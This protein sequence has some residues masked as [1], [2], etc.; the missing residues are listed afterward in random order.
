MNSPSL[1][2]SIRKV[3][4]LVAATL[5]LPAL[6]YAQNNQGDEGRGFRPGIPNGT[7]AFQAS[8]YVSGTPVHSAAQLTFFANGTIT[9]LRSSSF[10][11]T[12]V[13]RLMLKGTFTV[14]ADGSVS[15]SLITPSETVNFDAYFTPD[16]NTFTFV[17]TNPGTIL[18]GFATRGR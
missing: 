16:G 18:N 5:I 3:C 9:G 6:A 11:G 12:I 7:Y 13:S 1:H 14:N 8:G 10:G 2:N 4:T 15:L 17:E